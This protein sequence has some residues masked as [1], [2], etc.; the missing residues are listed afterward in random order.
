MLWIRHGLRAGLISAAATA[1]ALIGFGLA[2]GEPFAPL[3]AI[4][5]IALGSR[6][7]LFDRFDL[8]VTPI[9]IALH[10]LSLIVWGVLFALLTSRARGHLLW[11]AAALFT[12]I[13]YAVD[14]LLLPER[15]RPGFE[16]VLSATEVVSV[17]VLLA[18]TLALAMRLVRQRDDLRRARDT[19][20]LQNATAEGDPK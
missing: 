14:L 5:H 11:L 3:N 9:A 20:W 8:V 16:R 6:A 18:I 1:G 12:A 2:R 15:L 4:A 13:I 10:V 19:A 17:Y 7:M